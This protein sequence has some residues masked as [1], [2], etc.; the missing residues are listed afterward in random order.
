MKE[1][2]PS[3][4][5]N[6]IIIELLYQGLPLGKFSHTSEQIVCRQGRI[7]HLLAVRAYE[8]KLYVVSVQ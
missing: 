4:K 7:K 6:L 2:R 8:I 1:Q 5:F 3:N